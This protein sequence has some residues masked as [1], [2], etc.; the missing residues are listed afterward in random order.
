MDIHRFPRDEGFVRNYIAVFD[1]NV[2]LTDRELLAE[3]R[4]RAVFYGHKVPKEPAF[5]LTEVE[6]SDGRRL[7]V[8]YLE[9]EPQTHVS[10]AKKRDRSAVFSKILRNPKRYTGQVTHAR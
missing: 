4:T 6:L 2:D 3:A 9:T 10:A 1:L 5:E 8:G 7:L